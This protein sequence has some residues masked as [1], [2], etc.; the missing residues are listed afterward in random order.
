[1]SNLLSANLEN[2]SRRFSETNW[3]NWTGFCGKM[4]IK[5]YLEVVE[6]QV[7][8]CGHLEKCLLLL[9]SSKSFTVTILVGLMASGYSK[10]GR[11]PLDM[12]FYAQLTQ[13]ILNG[14]YKV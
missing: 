3:S 8:W 9:N 1:M 14:I 7:V 2:F 6:T 11:F 10:K 4:Y 13:K 12:W 5:S